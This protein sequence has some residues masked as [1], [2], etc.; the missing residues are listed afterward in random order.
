MIRESLYTPFVGTNDLG[1][2]SCWS[3]RFLDRSSSQSRGFRSRLARLVGETAALI[4]VAFPASGQL[5]VVGN[6]QLFQNE[7]GG[8]IEAGDR[9]SASLAAGDFD[10]D[11]ISDLAIGVPDEDITTIVD[12]GAVFVVY[13]S[14]DG[15]GRGLRDPQLIHQDAPG[16]LGTAEAGDRFGLV[17]TSGDFTGD[18]YDELVVGVPDEDLGS[19]V[20]AGAIHVFR[21]TPT[22]IDTNADRLYSGSSLAPWWSDR[23]GERFGG[24]LTTGTMLG[25]EEIDLLIGIPGG[26]GQPNFPGATVMISFAAGSLDIGARFAA[27][28]SPRD[29]GDRVGAA[30]AVGDLNGDEK[31]GDLVF[32][33]PFA[34]LEGDPIDAGVVWIHYEDS[35]FTPTISGASASSHFGSVLALGDF[36]RAGHE[37]LLI[38]VPSLDTNGIEEAGAVAVFDGPLATLDYLAQGQPSGFGGRLDPFDRFGE[39]VAVGDFNRDGYDDAAFGVPKEDLNDGAPDQII[40]AGLVHV[41]LGSNLG[42]TPDGNQ[43]WTLDGPINFGSFAGDRFGG[44]LAV[45][46]F[47]G[48]GVDDLAIGV[49]GATWNA[50]PQTGFLQILYGDSG[51]IFADGFESSDTSIW[52]ASAG[53]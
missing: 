39:V 42:L 12:A 18:G 30:I 13:G 23:A 25:N 4:A 16:I 28:P 1:A 35:S 2:P 17:L 8:V 34:E 6:H 7:M 37:Q 46:D 22:G 45:G 20:D 10:G 24:A 41:L 33:A 40:D 26:P 14:S 44:S 27:Y 48:D 9:F 21:G 19:L 49:P 36:R 11:G 53:E 31:S 29:A 47:N 32:G 52:S 38:G 5:V 15:L 50:Q 43:L 51:S 3:P